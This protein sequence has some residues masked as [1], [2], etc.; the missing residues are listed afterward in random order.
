[1]EAVRTARGR[2][3][4]PRS[5]S[6]PRRQLQRN[7]SGQS[8]EQENPQ[9][10]ATEFCRNWNSGACVGRG[11][12]PNGR[13]HICSICKGP[14]PKYNC[15]KKDSGSAPEMI[16]DRPRRAPKQNRKKR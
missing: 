9:D 6:P 7:D 3:L 15:P 8:A 5:R 10:P 13:K 16:K 4:Q 12:C 11:R 1:M 2:R 14:H